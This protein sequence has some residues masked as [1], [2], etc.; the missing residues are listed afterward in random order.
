MKKRHRRN[1]SKKPLPQPE[2]RRIKLGVNGISTKPNA[3]GR[4]WSAE[5][6]ARVREDIAP[7]GRLTKMLKGYTF[8]G[9]MEHHIT[10]AERKLGI[11]G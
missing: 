10:D 5:A 6:L 9:E 2:K 1:F 4:I 7:D 3:N 8:V 11:H